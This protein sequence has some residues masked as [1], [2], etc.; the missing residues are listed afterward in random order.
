M[1]KAVIISPKDANSKTAKCFIKLVGSEK[2]L[3]QH[4]KAYAAMVKSM[5]M[6]MA[7]E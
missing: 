6:Q 3:K 1:M 5:K 2:T 7:V 4:A